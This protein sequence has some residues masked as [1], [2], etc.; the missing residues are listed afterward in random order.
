[1]TP[2]DAI[3]AGKI[4]S[5]QGPS[6]RLLVSAAHTTKTQLE[7]RPLPADPGALTIDAVLMASV[8]RANADKSGSVSRICVAP[9]R[10]AGCTACL[11]TTDGYS[12]KLARLEGHLGVPCVRTALIPSMPS[13]P[14]PHRHPTG[15]RG[16]WRHLRRGRH[17]RGV[18][19]PYGLR[20]RS[21]QPSWPDDSGRDV[22]CGR[23]NLLQFQS[24]S[25]G[26]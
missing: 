18:D 1:M 9:E 5:N 23:D 21:K 12:G 13:S 7:L 20:A 24:M 10:V 19:L 11:L 4:A 17:I 8:T 22:R 16:T 2:T 15:H 3:L 26:A 25:E 14:V 6:R